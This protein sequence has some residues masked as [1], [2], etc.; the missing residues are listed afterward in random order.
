MGFKPV[1]YMRW[2]KTLALEEGI[3]NLA[4]SDIHGFL[5]REELGW[6]GLE[7]PI[8]DPHGDGLPLLREAIAARYRV[9]PSQVLTSQGASLANFLILSAWVRPGDHVLL[10]DPFYE[11]LGSVLEGLE[12]RI[13]RVAV[14]VPEGHRALLSAMRKF[15]STRWRAVVVTNPHN[16][17]GAR[18]EEAL[19]SELAAACD[20]RGAILLVDEVYRELLF[21]DPPACAARNRPAVVTTSSL[22]KAFGLGP[23]RIGWA[24]GR[25]DLIDTAIQIYDNLGVRHPTLVEALGAHLIGDSERMRSWTERLR[26]RLATNR[27]LLR[28]FLSG[29]APFE[30]EVSDVGIISFPQYRPIPAL[31]DADLFCKRARERARVALVPGRFFGRA[32]HVRI[33]VGGAEAQVARALEALDAFLEEVGPR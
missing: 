13:H 6:E 4:S 17:S 25:R 32:D 7:L 1:A 15:S 23:L 16:P 11:P 28:E 31:P 19:L 24:I 20:A 22:T 3:H 30:G 2:A 26:G 29:R 10:E 21:E 27:A 5:S 33:G 18:L 8:W 12:A 9:D 14:D